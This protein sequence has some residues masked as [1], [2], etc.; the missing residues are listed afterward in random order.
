MLAG[1]PKPASA[2][3]KSCGGARRPSPPR[4]NGP[5][6]GVPTAGA[7]AAR[8]AG[9]S[10]SYAS[11]SSAGARHELALRG[12]EL[13]VGATSVRSSD[14]R[15]PLHT[16]SRCERVSASDD[17]SVTRQ[18]G[19]IAKIVNGR[20]VSRW[21]RSVNPRSCQ[22][23]CSAL[24]NAIRMWSGRERVDAIGGSVQ[25]RVVADCAL[26][27][28]V[29]RVQPAAPAWLTDPQP[30]PRRADSHSLLHPGQPGSSQLTAVDPS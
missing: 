8:T 12:D 4:L 1:A 30:S 29:G 9:T 27:R 15:G 10:A 18:A 23:P 5:R 20:W 19:S 13:V 21:I 22:P 26:R 25:R 7:G 14:G 17:R 2:P 6:Q 11:G 16:T 3:D 28:D 24:R